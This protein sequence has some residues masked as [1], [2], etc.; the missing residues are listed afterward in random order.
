MFVADDMQR[1]AIVPAERC[2]AL[3]PRDEQS[4][5]ATDRKSECFEVL[6][7]ASLATGRRERAL[8]HFNSNANGSHFSPHTEIILSSLQRMCVVLSPR[9]AKTICPSQASPL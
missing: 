5:I 1:N 9:S 2:S 3:L 8:T 4:V 6:K 7:S